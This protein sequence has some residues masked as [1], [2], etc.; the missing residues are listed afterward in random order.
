MIKLKDILLEIGDASA[1]PFKVKGP[2]PKQVVN[3][4]LKMNGD[5][6]ND[7][8]W[9]PEDQKAIWEFDGDKGQSYTIEIAWN[10]KKKM[11]VPMR[12]IKNKKAYKRWEFSMNIG[13]YAK[14]EPYTGTDFRIDLSDIEKERTTNLGEQYRILATVVDT[15]IPVINEAVKEY[16]INTIYI[17]PKADKGEPESM[18][19]R[20]GRLYLAYIKK[21]IKKINVPVTAT[22]DKYQG[23]FA[24]KG[25]HISAG[26]SADDGYIRN[27][28]LS[29]SKYN[30]WVMPDKQM[31][32]RE[33]RVEHEKKGRQDF[34]NEQDFIQAVQNAE[35]RKINK[36]TDRRIGNRSHTKSFDE[37]H[38]LIKM[39]RSYPKYR[40]EESLRDM[41]KRFG[42][43]Q[44]M[45]MPIIFD[46]N[47]DLE[48][49]SGNTRMD[50]AFQMGIEPKALIV[51]VNDIN[52]ID[53]HSKLSRG[54][55]PDYYQLGTS[56][57]EPFDE[58]FADGK[59]PGRKG[60]SKRVGVSQKMSIAQLAKIAKTA[61]GER[62]RM[63]Q[64]NLNMKRGRKKKK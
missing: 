3:D 63:A 37:L 24:I 55:K 60:L 4:M 36:S 62:K 13:F 30:S 32:A 12:F 21:Q 43:N 19:N 33:F 52:E 49:F 48:I 64:W 34:A 50:I 47:G 38:D 1:K 29:E 44:P 17:I 59:K 42:N 45:D 7:D 54:H 18:D 15:A 27:E 40:N 11:G 28:S 5:R 2:S 31:L 23:G 57:F 46:D 61:T 14:V 35:I 9:L 6:T 41:Y 10:T 56:E 26:G 53:Y 58:N 22:E 51:K 25:G 39:Y 8:G 16:S 20:R